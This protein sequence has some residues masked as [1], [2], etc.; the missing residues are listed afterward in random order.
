[1][2]NLRQLEIFR[3]VMV[4]GSMTGAG[5]H[6]QMSQPAVTKAVRRMEDL[7]GFA[8]FRRSNG[9]VQPTPEALNLFRE[10]EKVFHS[11]GIVEKYA[12]DLK[13]S[14]SG[15][16][17]LACTPTLSC[18]FLTEAIAGFRR[19]RPRVRIWLQ[20]TK[21]KEVMEL[22][23]SG[24]IDLGLIYAPAEHPAVTVHPLFETQLVCVMNP[25]HPLARR[26]AIR[27]EDLHK[28]P[29][30]TNVRNEPIHDLLGAAFGK[31]D[32]D[33]QV[34]IGTNSTITACSLVMK[35]SG[36]AIVEPMGVREIFPTAVQKPFLPAVS[37]TPRIVQARH[38]APSRITRAFLDVLKATVA[39]HLEK[40]RD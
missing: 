35:G 16:L 3:A 23:A 37:V 8:L 1:M 28:E 29:I 32:L 6:L 10:V 26:A 19:D 36:V 5:K 27:P 4:A 18:S 13:E 21:T 9:R 38:V 39:Q 25:D 2:F 20:I 33:R 14:Q 40:G 34:M 12:R 7:V 22:A 24:Q 17:T 11:V 31:I 15:V 30:I